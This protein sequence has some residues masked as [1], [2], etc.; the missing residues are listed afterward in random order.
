MALQLQSTR[1]IPCRSCRLRGSSSCRACRAELNP[2]RPPS[3]PIPADKRANGRSRVRFYNNTPYNVTLFYLPVDPAAP[4]KVSRG[5]TAAT[6]DGQSLL[7]L[8][9][10]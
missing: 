9:Q 4:A 10:L 1:D 8:L 6:P 2:S 5:R 3:P 7:S